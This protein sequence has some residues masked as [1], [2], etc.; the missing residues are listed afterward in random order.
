MKPR[1]M[2]SVGLVVLLLGLS[3]VSARAGAGL[4]GFEQVTT[5]NSCEDC[6]TKLAS[7]LYDRV[8]LTTDIVDWPGTCVALLFGE[9]DLTFDC[10]GHLID[11]DDVA[12]DPDQ[13]IAFF[14]GANNVIRN[15]RV[16]DFSSGV[17]LWDATNHVVE[18]SETFS[19][20]AGID[21]GFANG[22][23]LRR[24]ESETNFTGIHLENSDSNS[25]IGNTACD[26]S[27]QDIWLESGTGNSGL[28]NRCDTAVG[29]ND[30]GTTG[31]S[32][33][34]STWLVYVPAVLRNQ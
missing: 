22:T 12:I 19:N 2:V 29:W 7:G 25:V 34:C 9:S 33:D 3:L 20:G 4:D 27:S 8:V 21:L 6:S 17:Y 10:A 28:G 14:H 23:I 30:Q 15:C 24:N 1:R 16:S 11:G 18:D 5:C 32:F 26:N 13:G 31:C